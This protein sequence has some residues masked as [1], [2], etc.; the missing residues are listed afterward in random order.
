MPYASQR[1]RNPHQLE[2]EQVPWPAPPLN[3]FVT[4]GYM[5]GVYDLVWDN[6]AYLSLNS[7]F[8][9][10]GTNVYRS[11]DS[12]FGPFERVTDL[13]LGAIF[14]RDR[15]DNV[16]VLDEEVTAERWVI[17][18]EHSTE[19]TGPRYVFQTEHRPIVQSNSQKVSA[20]NPADVFVRVDGVL[21]RVLRVDGPSGEVELDVFF[22]DQTETQ[23][24]EKP[25]VPGPNSKVTVSYRYNRLY[26]RTDLAQRVFYRV[27]TVGIPVTCPIERA[28]PQDL[29][30]TPLER[31]AATS[32]FEIEK[33]DWIWRE[34]VRR[35]QWVLNQGGERVKVFLRKQ[36]GTPCPC[37]QKPAYKQPIS[38]CLICYGTGI[39]D[40]YEG[41]Y[42]VIV[43]P[44]DSERRIAQKPEGRSIE[45]TYE[46]WMGPSPLVSQRDFLVKING[47]R[48]SIGSVRMPTNRGMVLQ[49]HF[50]IGHLDEQEIR[51]K[52]PIDNPRGFVV[53][54]LTPV[55]PPQTSPAAPTDKR[56]IPD[57]KE[58]RGRTVTWENIVY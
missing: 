4:S 34:A 19:M 26:L 46:V 52:I 2:L 12:E 16:V 36:V 13:P 3:L 6:P 57:E 24:R 56:H 47:E 53:N 37:N 31:A 48:Y 38:D 42:D 10:L 41:P 14:W 54:Q 35:N 28:Q 39:V 17:R 49:Q 45:H 40:G 20:W 21:A 15:T 23:T 50:N 22:Y 44:D 25:V 27:T 8:T 7:R 11:F 18:G 58:L 1:D 33:L 32:N 51:Y 43:A 30:E 5:P 29:V 9:I 55:I